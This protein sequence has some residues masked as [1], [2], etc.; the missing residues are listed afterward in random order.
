MFVIYG[1]D[2]KWIESAFRGTLADG[3]VELL[4][5]SIPWNNMTPALA[6]LCRVHYSDRFNHFISLP[7][8]SVWYSQMAKTVKKPISGEYTYI[9]IHSRNKIA[10]DKNFLLFL[11][12]KYDNVSIVLWFTDTVERNWVDVG[13]YFAL[14][15][16]LYDCIVTYDPADAKRFDFY[17][18]ET[19]YSKIEVNEIDLPINDLMYI[20]NAKLEKDSCRFNMIIDVYEKLRSQGLTLDFHIVGVPENMQKHA[21]KI[22]YNQPLPYSEVIKH[23]LGSRCILEVP[24]LGE[25]GTTLRVHEA[26][27]YDRKLLTSNLNLSSNPLFDSNNM[28]LF[29]NA[30]EIDMEFLRSSSLVPYHNKDL[31]SPKRFLEKVAKLCAKDQINN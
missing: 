17:Y 27:A 13:E 14:S 3:S 10:Y 16:S 11:R 12:R 9:I 6:F 24:Q 21:D 5:G 8:K 31:L 26:I 18:I 7:G 2:A 20:G 23:V 30:E 29:K 19:P 4:N 15:R 1:R 22:C 28:S 25:T